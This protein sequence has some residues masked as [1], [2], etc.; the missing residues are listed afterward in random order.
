M[1]IFILSLLHSEHINYSTPAFSLRRA[2]L[3]HLN[4]RWRR[5]RVTLNV[6]S[7]ETTAYAGSNLT[8]VVVRIMK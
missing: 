4:C 5:S 6:G 1:L 3:E 2:H 8:T 7:L